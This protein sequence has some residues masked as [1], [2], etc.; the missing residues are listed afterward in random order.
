MTAELGARPRGEGQA[1]FRVWAPEAESVTLRLGGRDVSLE[2]AACGMHEAVVEAA[3]GD[4]YSF[5]LGDTELPDPASRWQPKGLRG[6][7]RVVE[8]PRLERFDTP[9]MQ[10]LVLYEL[11]IGTFSA[12]GTFEGAIPHLRELAELGVNAIEVMPVAEFPGK[13]GWGYDGVYLSAPQ[14]SYGRRVALLGPLVAS[15]PP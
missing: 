15:S 3:P 1:E 14:S 7:S 11:H 13:R 9:S 10:D 12:E 6:P 4:D 5:V 8:P 2:P